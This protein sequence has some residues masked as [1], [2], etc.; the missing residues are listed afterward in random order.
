MTR[1]IKTVLLLIGLCSWATTAHA[2]QAERTNTPAAFEMMKAR[3]LWHLTPNAAG[4]QWDAPRSFSDINASYRIRKGDFKRPQDGQMVKDL[5]FNTEGAVYVGGI[6]AYGRFSYRRNT[7]RDANFN[8]SIL[9]P[10]RGMPYY[11]ADTNPSDWNRQTY[12]MAFRVATPRFFDKLTLGLEGSYLA[13]NGAKQRDPRTHNY[14]YMLRIRP[15]LAWSLNERNH[16]GA[17]FD[18]FSLKEE[19]FL[20]QVNTYVDQ[21][22]YFMYGLGMS[23]QAIGSGRSS[24]YVG[25]N[26][27][28]GLQYEYRGVHT[29][30]LLCADYNFKAEKVTDGLSVPRDEGGVKD[31]RWN[32]SL[33]MNTDSQRSHAHFIT[34][35]VSG[36]AID[37]IEYITQYDNTLNQNGYVTLHSDVR[38]RYQMQ[39]ARLQYDWVQAPGNEFDWKAGA[40]FSYTQIED[41]YLLPRSEKSARNWSMGIRGSKNFAL[42]G[43]LQQRILIRAGY[44]YLGNI[45]GKY[46]YGGNHADYPVIKDF[47][48]KDAQYLNSSFGAADLSVTYSRKYKPENSAN[49]YLRADALYKHT[50]KE[51]GGHRQE[52]MLTV[53][54]SF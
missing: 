19:G 9:D 21:T 25:H 36:K 6:Y 42:P 40:D 22:T 4:L 39:K 10:F 27:G 26:M 23:V 54:C 52:L 8:A 46:V 13:R 53:G 12:D 41:L 33:H 1:Y 5:D 50:D 29:R 47:E 20:K 7:E 14:F 49:L 31:Q 28:G 17:H 38:S 3:N 45:S 11:V 15:A 24:N 2:Q 32:V 34:A 18:Y 30:W 44:H 48:I 37:G 43:R 51:K 16:L 35:S